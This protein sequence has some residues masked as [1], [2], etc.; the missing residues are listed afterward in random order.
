MYA[1]F[2]S[3]MDECI[4][5]VLQHLKSDGLEEETIVVFQ[6]DH[7]H[8]M[9]QRTFG[10]GGSAGPYRGA[11]FSL[12]EGG[13][14]VP[15]MISWPG[16]LPAGATR[17]QMAIAT[18]WLPTIAELCE[19]ELPKDRIDGKSLVPV[20]RSADAP[21]PHR[22]LHW[23]S[24][25]GIGGKPQWAVRRGP[26]K[27][28]GNPNDTSKTAPL[29]ANDAL[30]LS[31]LDEDARELTN[32]SGDYPDIVQELQRLHQQWLEDTASQ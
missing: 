6:S 2:V 5:E 8:S 25:R 15:A 14:R 9:E 20:I 13:I 26:W 10:G 24:G 21:S 1:E 22:V 23:Q 18:D 11:K 17:D 3:T 30:F 32:I 19:V 27:L 31:N 4:G 16:N 7:G 12:F 28:I 29:T